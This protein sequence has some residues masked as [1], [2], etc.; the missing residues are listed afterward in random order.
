VL[1]LS[2]DHGPDPG[3]DLGRGRCQAQDLERVLDRRERVPQFVTQRGEELVLAA[4]GLAERFLGP[5]ALGDFL[6]ELFIDTG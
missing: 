6:P 5:A 1:H 3:D 4:V 2:F